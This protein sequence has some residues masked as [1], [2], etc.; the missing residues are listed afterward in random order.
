MFAVNV[1]FE[2]LA[3]KS[4]DFL[5][6]PTDLADLRL[7]PLISVFAFFLPSRVA[8][9]RSARLLSIVVGRRSFDQAEIERGAK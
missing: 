8:V 5:Y 9:N 2:K 3:P 6:S 1:G 4:D 7:L